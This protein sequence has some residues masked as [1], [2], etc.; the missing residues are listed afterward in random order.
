[1]RE[2]WY[3]QYQGLLELL[4]QRQTRDK[5]GPS[6][7]RNI[8]PRQRAKQELLN[9]GLTKI[10]A[11]GFGLVALSSIDDNCYLQLILFRL[12]EIRRT[13]AFLTVITVP[14]RIMP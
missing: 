3:I 10:G 5:R 4:H 9:K 11:L 2:H 8:S 6:N 14:Y 7:E 13:S 12:V 1:M